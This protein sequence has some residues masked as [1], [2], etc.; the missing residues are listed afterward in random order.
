[1]LNEGVLIPTFYEVS[2]EYKL[3]S[4]NSSDGH[5]NKCVFVGQENEQGYPHGL[6]RVFTPSGNVFE[7]QISYDG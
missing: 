7:G 1:M 6:A 5:S 2:K 3:F 4:R